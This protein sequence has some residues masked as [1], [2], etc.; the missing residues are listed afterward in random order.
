MSGGYGRA[1]RSLR[2]KQV[3]VKL[4]LPFVGEIAGTWEPA[5]AERE[6]AW[7][8]Y[9]ELITRVTVVEL[10]PDEGLVREA[11]TSVYSVFEST[12]EILRKYGPAVAPRGRK[13]TITFGVLAIG[14]LNGAL[15]PLLTKWHPA[16]A[17][18]EAQRPDSVN[19][20]Q[21]ERD[22]DQLPMVRNELSRTRASL[23]ELAKILADVA[24]AAYLLPEAPNDDGAPLQRGGR[25]MSRDLVLTKS[26]VLSPTTHA[27]LADRLLPQVSVGYGKLD[28]RTRAAGS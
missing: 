12:R 3:A 19:P 27:T 25:P 16:L 24:G 9:V 14:V 28:H 11:L 13:E 2:P 7:E 4:R 5:E 10:R 6:A 21:H 20:V 8:L 22:W 1:R 23:A 18:W 26:V 17:A 15:R